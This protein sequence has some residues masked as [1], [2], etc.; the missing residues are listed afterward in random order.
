MFVIYSLKKYIKRGSLLNFIFEL[1]SI[2]EFHR[3]NLLIVCRYYIVGL[4]INIATNV[5]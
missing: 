5:S 2:L 1:K 4:L 3:T